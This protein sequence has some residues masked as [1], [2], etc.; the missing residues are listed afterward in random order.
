MA[1]DFFNGQ[2][3]ILTNSVFSYLALDGYDCIHTWRRICDIILWFIE[4]LWHHSWLNS[5]ICYFLQLCINFSGQTLQ[6]QVKTFSE[7]NKIILL[8]GTVSSS[9]EFVDIFAQ[10]KSVSK[11]R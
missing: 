1:R 8:D 5:K 6:G 7:E 10:K 11:E 2:V 3:R 4:L 9:E